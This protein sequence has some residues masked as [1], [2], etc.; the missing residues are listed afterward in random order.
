MIKISWVCFA[1]VFVG[2]SICSADS[3]ASP[4]ETTNNEINAVIYYAAITREKANQSANDEQKRLRAKIEVLEQQ[5]RASDNA[6]VTRLKAELAELQRKFIASKA[7]ASDSYAAEIKD[8]RANLLHLASNAERLGAISQRGDLDKLRSAREKLDSLVRGDYLQGKYASKSEYVIDLK[9]L[10]LLA[11]SDR[12]HGQA[13]IDEII[14]RQEE[15]TRLSPT[16]F[17]DWLALASLYAGANA[18]HSAYQAADKALEVAETDVQKADAYDLLVDFA[19]K[20]GDPSKAISAARKSLKLK[21]D[22]RGGTQEERTKSVLKT[23]MTLAELLVDN[24]GLSEAEDVI[25]QAFKNIKKLREKS[26]TAPELDAQEATLLLYLG[27]L[28]AHQ[29]QYQKALDPLKKSVNLWK[30]IVTENPESSAHLTSYVQTL[31]ALFSFQS[32]FEPKLSIATADERVTATRLLLDLRP[33][34]EGVLRD[35]IRYSEQAATT[36]AK[37]NQYRSTVRFLASM[38]EHTQLALQRDPDDR[39]LKKSNEK[40]MKAL[41][42]ASAPK[43]KWPSKPNE[44]DAN[45]MISLLKFALGHMLNLSKASA[46]NQKSL[47]KAMR[48]QTALIA[49]WESYLQCMPGCAY[50]MY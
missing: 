11:K 44:R 21:N 33:D 14:T 45:S 10:A 18:S 49:R 16:S 19:A 25:G 17:D 5:L 30:P 2:I 6:S 22:L 37:A 8:M 38:V 40:A 7:E 32:A 20:S 4:S 13:S 28:R 12:Y 15:I 29:Q 46:V 27:V 1:L 47:E 23:Q 24:A 50:P 48:K 26:P 41:L 9:A 31:T 43:I 3:I 35:M 39:E 36:A 42:L 34:D